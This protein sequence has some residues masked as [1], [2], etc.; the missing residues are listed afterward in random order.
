MDNKYK[1]LNNERETVITYNDAEK[2]ATVYTLNKP[3]Q[4]KLE[5]FSEKNSEV[6]KTCEDAYSQ[7]YR[8]PKRFVRFR[9]PSSRKEMTE[10]QKEALRLRM[11]K[12]HEAKNK[13]IEK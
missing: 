12:M 11:A 6:V 3:L 7:T 10:D 4:R 13:N 9:L 2:E 1:P 8:M 5:K